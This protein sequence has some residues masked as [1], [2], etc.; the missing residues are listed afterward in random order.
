MAE[1]NGDGGSDDEL[2]ETPSKKAKTT[3]GGAKVVK[4]EA[5]N[6]DEDLGGDTE[7][8][9]NGSASEEAFVGGKKGE[10]GVEGEDGVDGG[11]EEV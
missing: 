11:D 4:K 5:T 10:K 8:L 3:K 7:E 1:A 9:S 2:A 6:G